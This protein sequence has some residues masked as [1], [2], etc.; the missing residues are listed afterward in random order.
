MRSSE[1]E[2]QIRFAI[3][4]FPALLLKAIFNQEDLLHSMLF[5]EMW[6]YGF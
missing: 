6:E 1:R 5:P 2:L 4:Q 3:I